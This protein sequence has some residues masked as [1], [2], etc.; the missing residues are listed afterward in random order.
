MRRNFGRAGRPSGAE[1]PHKKYC[2]FLDQGRPCEFGCYHGSYR[3]FFVC[4]KYVRGQCHNTKCKRG[5]H[6]LKR[7]SEG[8]DRSAQR[9]RGDGFK[10][11]A[12]D[13]E[14][15][16]KLKKHL[17]TLGL[18]ARCEDLLDYDAK[19]IESVYRKLAS[20]RHPDKC[21]GTEEANQ[22]FK[23]LQ[24]T[25]VSIKHNAASCQPACRL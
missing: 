7:R 6:P 1:Q 22:R 21:G 20:K 14:N 23:Q 12:A 17:A 9:S 18:S 11:Y 8:E 5:E 3:T 25:W 16:E 2:K 24:S 15:E 13:G 4:H 10:P 19:T